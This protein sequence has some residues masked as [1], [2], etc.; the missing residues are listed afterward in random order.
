M[1]QTPPQVAK[2]RKYLIILA[3]I[4][5]S[6]IAIYSV[7]LYMN[8]LKT[9]EVVIA[10]YNEN[11][12][13]VNKEFPNE[14]I[15]IYNKGKDDIT[16]LP[17]WTI[18]KLPNIGRETHTYLYHIINNY[19][20]LADRT[21]FLQGHPFDHARHIYSPLMQYKTKVFNHLSNKCKNIIARCGNSF[22]AYLKSYYRRDPDRLDDQSANLHATLHGSF[23]EGVTDENL[24]EFIEKILK[25]KLPGNTVIGWTMG[26][27]FAVEK[28]T[29]LRH[30]IEYYKNLLTVLDRVHPEEVYF[31][32]KSWDIVFDNGNYNDL[33]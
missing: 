1:H 2:L 32:E 11:L 23:R 26:A 5:F 33:K 10:R 17:N 13:W 18:T 15:T 31:I 28:E 19:N 7:A 30:N 16:L 25:R 12:D 22:S 6:C 4:V 24:E 3:A 14:K 9:F 20:N 27:Q 8:S 21:L 29:I